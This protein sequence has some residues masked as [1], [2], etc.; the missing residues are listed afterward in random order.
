MAKLHD[1]AQYINECYGMIS[2][3]HLQ[4]LLF[5][6]QAWS[7]KIYGRKMFEEDV[8]E[9]NCYDVL[10]PVQ[11]DDGNS[12]NLGANELAMINDILEAYGDVC[13]DRSM[14]N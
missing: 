4:C 9:L 1:V 3:D 7:L 2:K 6:C 5:F 12:D 14:V 11:I 13:F 10:M 8:N